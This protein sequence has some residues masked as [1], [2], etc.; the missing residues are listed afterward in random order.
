MISILESKTVKCIWN[1]KKCCII[2]SPSPTHRHCRKTISQPCRTWTQIGK[3]KT[4]YCRHSIETPRGTGP[5][6]WPTVCD[7]PT[8]FWCLSE[9]LPSSRWGWSCGC[10]R[11]RRISTHRFADISVRYPSS[12]AWSVCPPTTCNGRINNIIPKTIVGYE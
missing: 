8:V 2:N 4:N 7:P 5:V 9:R 11:I 6:G 1:L 12:W 10:W 3:N